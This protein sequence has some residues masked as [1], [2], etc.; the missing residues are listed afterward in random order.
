VIAATLFISFVAPLWAGQQSSGELHSA[1]QGVTLLARMPE[2]A[3]VAGFIMPVPQAL[4]EEGQTADVVVL[5]QSWTFARGETLDAQGQ[6]IADPQ[7]TIQLF[8][9]KP[10]HLATGFAGSTSFHGTSQV[11]TFPLA[12]G[13]DPAK[14]TLKDAQI[15][16]IVRSASGESS[17]ASVRITVIAL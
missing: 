4:L 13:F 14:G 10:Q 16:L 5:R 2:T 17:P 12:A 15:L 8:I 6:V 11:R 9:S 1:G 3:S 7:T